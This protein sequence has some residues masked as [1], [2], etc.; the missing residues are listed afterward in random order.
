VWRFSP[1]N[2]ND[3]A[4]DAI[5]DAPCAFGF[6]LNCRLLCASTT[7][8]VPKA[9]SAKASARNNIALAVAWVGSANTMLAATP[10]A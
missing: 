2:I 5:A 4:S 10:G 6:A 9:C 8:S 7:L 3:W 1:L